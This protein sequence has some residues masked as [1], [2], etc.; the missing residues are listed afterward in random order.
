LYFFRFLPFFHL[1]HFL[2]SG[3]SH[4][5]YRS[6]LG[7]KTDTA[8]KTPNAADTKP[9]TPSASTVATPASTEAQPTTV[10]PEIDNTTSTADVQAVQ[11]DSEVTPEFNPDMYT[12]PTS[13]L[14][15]T[16]AAMT[17]QTSADH[18]PQVY[19]NYGDNSNQQREYNPNRNSQRSNNR[20]YNNDRRNQRSD[21]FGSNSNNNMNNRNSRNY[22]NNNINQQQQQQQQQQFSQQYAQTQYTPQQYAQYQQQLQQQQQ[23][24][25]QYAVAYAQY[26]QQFPQYTQQQLAAMTPQQQYEYQYQQQQYAAYYNA[27]YMQQYQHQLATA[28]GQQQGRA[29]TTPQYTTA[30][31][32]YPQQ[33]QA[34]NYMYQGYPGYGTP[35]Y[36]Q[37]QQQQQQ[38]QQAVKSEETLFS[39]TLSI[40]AS[41][42]QPQLGQSPAQSS[43]QQPASL[44]PGSVPEQPAPV[45]LPEAESSVSQTP[46]QPFAVPEPPALIPTQQVVQPPPAPQLTATSVPVTPAVHLSATS[47]PATPAMPI[48]PAPEKEKKVITVKRKDGTVVDLQ[49][50]KKTPVVTPHASVTPVEQKPEETVPQSVETKKDSVPSSV[51]IAP[52]TAVREESNAIP[53]MPVSV[54][55]MKKKS[56]A[57]TVT[58]ETASSSDSSVD[59]HKESA[60]KDESASASLS[61]N[62]ED[63]GEAAIP[64]PSAPTAVGASPAVR[65]LRQTK[66][67][68]TPVSSSSASSGIRKIYAKADILALKPADESGYSRNL[69]G[70]L[71]TSAEGSAPSHGGKGGGPSYGG[72][73][74]GYAGDR[75]SKGGPRGGGGN[76]YRGDSSPLQPDGS[77]W[78]KESLPQPKKNK[79]IPAPPPKKKEFDPLEALAHEV[80]T[81]LNKIA[82]QTFDKLLTTLLELKLQNVAMLDKLVELIFEKAIYEPTFTAMYADL[83]LQ[84]KEKS[85]WQFFITVKAHESGDYFWIRDFSFREEAAGP[86]F[87]LSTAIE[88]FN[89]EETPEMKPWDSSSQ[90]NTKTEVIML[91]NNLLKVRVLLFSLLFHYLIFVCSCFLIPVSCFLFP[92]FFCFFR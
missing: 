85:Q 60:K 36:A 71:S 14:T 51:D 47:V 91:K 67:G 56:R 25:Q 65:S 49:S 62:W 64:V 54:S 69:L 52:P 55:G 45:S 70:N 79:L 87:S 86:Y 89:T 4:R 21:S 78:S 2:Q 59:T 80:T 28:Q 39:Q 20:N 18:S 30:G 83:C 48:T 53:D 29:T 32:Y 92:L 82:P 38:P 13:T 41:Q 16:D 57:G 26:M 58:E 34:A 19:A 27:L 23:Q 40:P 50:L 74:G 77:G 1:L 61:E 75:G 43:L 17:Q 3:E 81:I 11:A 12:D 22:N 88:A 44:I 9:K 5:D 76:E 15:S 90:V 35:Q 37:Q 31:Y 68:Q 6:A 7:I 24:Q 73:G 46:A 84:L 72:K 42:Q 63:G 66:F 10:Q 33:Q 8:A